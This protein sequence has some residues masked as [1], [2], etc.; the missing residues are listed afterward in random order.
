MSTRTIGQM[1]EDKYQT[2]TDEASTYLSTLKDLGKS[3]M[4]EQIKVSSLHFGELPKTPLFIYPFCEENGVESDLVTDSVES[5]TRIYVTIDQT[6]MMLR[7]TAFP[8]LFERLKIGGAALSKIPTPIL[9]EHLNNYARYVGGQGRLLV[10][11]GKINAVLGKDYRLIPA[12]SVMEKATEF[13]F[14]D[15]AKFV[16]GNISHQSTEA[17]WKTE[18][19]TLSIPFTTGMQEVN[20]VQTVM[21]KTSDCGFSGINIFP[22]MRQ[23]DDKN[24]L[25]YCLPLRQAHIGNASLEDFEKRLGYIARSFTDSISTINRLSGIMLRYPTNVLFALMKSLKIPPKYG[26]VL[27]E[28]KRIQWHD[29]DQTAFTVYSALSEILSLVMGGD[30]NA[31]SIAEYQERF[32]R[33]LRF[34]FTEFDVP[35][36]F[37]DVDKVLSPKVA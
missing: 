12:E 25:M 24:G 2:T 5:G 28:K 35:G 31:K 17:V 27:L 32:A 15:R 18:N 26:A 36:E 10:A 1:F 9:V 33:G 4:V 13:F 7:D 8:S 14:A 30:E 19:C 20:F 29:T 3:R 6:P 22:V 11:N 34:A 16:Y 23:E 21:V 37:N